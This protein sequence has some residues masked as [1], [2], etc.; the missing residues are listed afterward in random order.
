MSLK[1]MFKGWVGEIQGTIAKKILMDADVY[2][3]INNVT[4]PTT[5]GT[6]QIDH[7]IVSRYGIFVIE[8]KNMGGWIFGDEKSPQWTQSL[9]GK[10]FKFQNP[11]HQNYRHTKALS[12]FLGIDHDKIFS[13]VMFWGD[14]QFK[15][16]MPPNVMARGYVTYIKS[17]TDVLFLDDEL[18]QIATAIKEG[19]LPKTWATRRQHVADL[20]KRFNSITACPKCASP[21]VLRTPKSG[22]NAGS[23]FYGCSKYPAC[24]Y[25]GKVEG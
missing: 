12:D 17:K 8:T 10:K 24:R 13:V 14:C 16:P 11:L 18:P 25:V 3:D 20:K 4:I 6:T 15:T 2:T 7:V 19:M 1:S 21:L 23:Q 5:N 22:A 9:F